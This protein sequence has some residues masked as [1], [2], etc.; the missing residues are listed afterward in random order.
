MALPLVTYNP[1]NMETVDGMPERLVFSELVYI[2]EKNKS[3][4]QFKLK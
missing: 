3:I 1:W 2:F 4:L